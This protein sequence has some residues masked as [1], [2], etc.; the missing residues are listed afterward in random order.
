MIKLRLL[1][2]SLIVLSGINQTIVAQDNGVHL[3]LKTS[4]LTS[5]GSDLPFWFTS[6]QQ[7]IFEQ[8]CKNYQLADFKIDKSF[9]IDAEKKWDYLYGGRL[10]YANGVSSYHQFNEWYA[11]IKYK[12]FYFKAGA[13]PEETVYNGLSSTNGDMRWS[14]NARP[15][16]RIRLAT[17]EYIPLP[18]GKNSNFWKDITYKACYDEGFLND[19]KLYVKHAHLHHKQLH[20]Q[21]KLRNNYQ[22]T[23]G[24]DHYNMWGGTSPDQGPLPGFKS[25]LRYVLVLNGSKGF[26]KSDQEYVAGNSLGRYYFKL[27]HQQDQS[28][29]T[30]YLDHPFEDRVTMQ[31]FPDNLI[32]VVYESTQKKR[33]SNLL[34]E[35]MITNDQNINRRKGLDDNGNVIQDHIENYFQHGTYR[36]GFSYCDRMIAS[37]FFSPMVI[38]NGINM[39]TGNNRVILFHGGLEGY[40]SDRFKWK[41]LLS[42]SMNHGTF[43]RIYNR[44][45]PGFFEHWKNQFSAYG[46]LNYQIPTKGW[47]FSCALATDQGEVLD[48][49]IG[50]QLSIRKTISF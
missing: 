15:M 44:I 31:N 40:F 19:N 26:N 25:Y 38:I 18:F 8:S 2:L 36:S 6:N 16:P 50:I 5:G 9:R 24:V 39:G 35:F 11:G 1:F 48:D 45:N 42:Y 43:D 23:F 17:N 41:T 32:G 47:D 20:F 3:S 34:F 22:F 49:Q 37:P 7:G 29:L 46:E 4:G 10:V 21:K 13:F 14:N 27:E 30:V 33:I 28:K 12:S